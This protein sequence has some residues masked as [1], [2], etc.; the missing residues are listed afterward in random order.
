MTLPLQILAACTVL[1]TLVSTPLWPWLPEYLV[2][3]VA[4]FDAH[5]LFNAGT[6]TLIVVSA[7][8]VAGGIGLGWWFY[9]L[10]P[11]EKPDEVD[12][13]EQQFPE[14]FGWSRGKFFVDELY[15]A[16]FV[17]WNAQLGR[18][19]NDLD[20]QVLDLLVS[21]VGWVTTGCAHV[22]KLFDEFVV[23][24]LF[25]AGCGEVR[26]GSEV[27]SELQNGQIHQYLRSIG[28]ALILFVF[29]LA[30]GCNK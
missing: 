1:L 15:A 16:T 2:N 12:P 23:N 28:V 17:K 11:A 14:Q 7:V 4:H 20:R 9:G 6:L 8:V 25:D 27:A 18:A 24:K 13:L 5:H 30:V 10:L 26:R 29:I 22:A 19:C 21:V 3:E